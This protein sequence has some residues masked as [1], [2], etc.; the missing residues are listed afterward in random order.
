VAKRKLDLQQPRVTLNASPTAAHRYPRY[1]LRGPPPP[2]QYWTP[3]KDQVQGRLKHRHDFSAV[4]LQKSAA[5]P[6]LYLSIFESWCAGVREDFCRQD[7]EQD[8][9]SHRLIGDF[10]V[11]LHH[12]YSRG[13]E[14]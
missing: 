12:T 7:I 1:G 14:R 2:G 4:L 5:P 10:H 11:K 9:R 13:G 6:K 8:D 3:I